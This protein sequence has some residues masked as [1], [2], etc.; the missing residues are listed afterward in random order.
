MWL[1]RTKPNA[2]VLTS[3]RSHL[4][5]LGNIINY[6]NHIIDNVL[7]DELWDEYFDVTVCHYIFHLTIVGINCSS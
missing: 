5:Y 2:N 1:P 3:V 7:E 6:H 4:T